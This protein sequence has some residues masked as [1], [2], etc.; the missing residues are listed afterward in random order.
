MKIHILITL[1]T[2]TVFHKSRAT[3]LDLNTASGLLLNVLDIC[4]AMTY[5][6]S[7]KIEARKWFKGNGDLLLRPFALFPGLAMTTW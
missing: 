3:A 5:N 6:L 1:A 4:T 2:S 7:T